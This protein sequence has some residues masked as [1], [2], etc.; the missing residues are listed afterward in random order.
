LYRKQRLCLERERQKAAKDPESFSFIGIDGMDQSVCRVPWK[1]KMSKDQSQ[2]GSIKFHVTLVHVNNKDAMLFVDPGHIP[3]DP[4]LTIH[5]L[6]ET[7]EKLARQGKLGQVL[8]LQLDNTCTSSYSFVFII[9]LPHFLFFNVARENKN[10]TLI[11]FL[12][13]LV[14]K[15]VFKKITLAFLIVGHT[16]CF[17]DQIFS[18]ISKRIAG[19]DSRL[20]P[21]EFI[22]L[23]PDA[24]KGNEGEKEARMVGNTYNIREWLNAENLNLVYHSNAHAFEFIE[25]DGCFSLFVFPLSF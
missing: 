3:H 20:T 13:L 23:I 17:L 4:N 5:C 19:S 16:H 22:H 24:L 6:M 25:E 10:K 11:A 18:T 12:G 21:S 9:S 8:T 1:P 15:G 7:I 2:S 14:L